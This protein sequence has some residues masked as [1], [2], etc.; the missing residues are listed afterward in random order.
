LPGHLLFSNIMQN[1]KSSSLNKSCLPK[2]KENLKLPWKNLLKHKP[3]L[4]RFKNSWKDF[5][6]NSLF[7]WMRSNNLKIKLIKPKKW[8]TL[9]ELLSDH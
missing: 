5:K 1:L 3:N 2:K 4:P 6:K 8:L 9:P 7:L